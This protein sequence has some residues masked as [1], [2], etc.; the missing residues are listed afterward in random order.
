MLG[1]ANFGPFLTYLYK[2]RV[3]LFFK[4]EWG[5]GIG[6]GAHGVAKCGSAWGG[7]YP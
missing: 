1:E 2:K 4:Q 6:K 7:T 5:E 3:G